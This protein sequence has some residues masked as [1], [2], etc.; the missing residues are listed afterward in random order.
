MA[1]ET[2]SAR[3]D[4]S[5]AQSGVD[6][7]VATARANAGETY[8]HGLADATR[9]WQQ[10]DAWNKRHAVWGNLDTTPPPNTPSWNVA[11]P[12]AETAYF[13][14]TAQAARDEVTWWGTAYL[15][16]VE[17][18]KGSGLFN[19]RDLTRMALS[20]SWNVRLACSE[21]THAFEA[22]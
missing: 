12:G 9:D 13:N 15:A 2:A 10:S 3:R 21:R 17:S 8:G 14:A 19:Q 1:Q 16:Q 7:S 18:R 4:G 6:V 5:V 22:R 20:H 11:V